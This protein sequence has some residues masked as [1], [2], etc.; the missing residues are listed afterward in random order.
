MTARVGLI[1]WSI[2]VG[3]TLESQLDAMQLRKSDGSTWCLNW[4]V[5]DG[6]TD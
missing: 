3:G 6:R 4:E 5:K 1:V 2:S